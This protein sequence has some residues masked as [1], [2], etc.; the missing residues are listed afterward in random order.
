MAQAVAAL[1]NVNG[2]NNSSTPGTT[3]SVAINPRVI[4]VLVQT[5]AHR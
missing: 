2:W 3:S 1:R 4:R 5:A